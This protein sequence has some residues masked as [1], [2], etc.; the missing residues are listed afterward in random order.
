[1]AHVPS[2]FLPCTN[3]IYV[4]VGGHPLTRSLH[5]IQC[6]THIFLQHLR[7]QPA[8]YAPDI[9]YRRKLQSL[10]PFRIS[11]HHAHALVALVF[12]CEMAG[13]L[14]EGLCRRDAY[15]HRHSDPFSDLCHKVG[16]KLRNRL[17][18]DAVKMQ[19][20]LI[21]RIYLDLRHSIGQ[22]GHD[23]AGKVSVQRIVRRKRM[24]LPLVHIMLHLIERHAHLYA[25][26]LAF[27]ASR[28]YT[29]IVVGK[30]NDGLAF[31][32][33]PEDPFARDEEIIAV[34]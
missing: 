4:E 5:E 34:H 26:G 28:H 13:Y 11:I 30:H 20:S 14:G 7:R 29:A 10:K 16:T 12:L 9:I 2:Q 24:E 17:R 19:K 1:M 31:Q 3:G 6:R 32:I 33:R 21:Y 15:A 8:A 25:H 22:K 18:I 23:A 27:I